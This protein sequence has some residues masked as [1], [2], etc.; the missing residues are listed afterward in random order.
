MG[1]A[2]MQRINRYLKNG[3]KIHTFVQGSEVVKW[4]G[5][6]YSITVHIQNIS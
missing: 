5:L 4:V 3:K 1:P 6:I 2:E